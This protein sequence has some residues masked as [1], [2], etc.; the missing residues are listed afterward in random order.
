MRPDGIRVRDADPMYYLIPY[1]LTKKYDA[2]NMVTLDIPVEPMHSYM[3]EKRREGRTVS[4]LA[5]V[6]TAYLRTA[7][8][9]PAIN[10][11][12]TNK[13]VYQHKDVTV[14]MVVLR[15]DSNDDTMSKIYLENTDNVFDVQ[16]KIEKYIGQ[17]RKMTDSN[18]LDKVMRIICNLSILMSAAIGLVKLLDRYGL[19]PKALIKV[20][21][22]HASLLISNLASIRTNHIY[23]HVY[24]FG[25]TSIAITMGNMREVPRRTKGGLIHDRC[26]PLGVV[27]DERICSGHYLAQAF[28]RLKELLRNPELLERR[29]PVKPS[30]ADGQSREADTAQINLP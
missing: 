2:M 18:V 1:F 28:A 21:P 12:I 6:L 17:N 25:T 22:F 11:F 15:P 5:L 7:E 9:Y 16:N 20:S 4:H 27:M 10:R 14:S 30:E 8:E 24:D 29:K 3:N 26:L 23:H 19:L 13:K